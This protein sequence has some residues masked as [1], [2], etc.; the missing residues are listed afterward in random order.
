MYAIRMFGFGMVMMPV[1]TAGLNQIPR[2]LI[3]HGSAVTNT[4]RQ[5][6]ASIGTGLLVTAMTTAERAGSNFPQI[7]NPD[8]FGAIVAF[9]MIAA[10]TF[11]SLILGFKVTKTETPTDEQWEKGAS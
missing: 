11:V 9:G 2:K 6:S 1:N 4:I 7:A 5:M 8:I 3:P 10:L